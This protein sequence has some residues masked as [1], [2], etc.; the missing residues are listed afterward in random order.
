MLNP[1]LAQ[2]MAIALHELATNAGKYGAL[3]VPGGSVC[4]EWALA[5]DRRLVLRW[6][7]VG[8]P[9]VKPPTRSG[10]GTNVME[11]HDT[12]PT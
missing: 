5:T 7:E 6:T 10:F 3:S 4:V 1:E 2:A 9:P 12:R 8:G 11:A